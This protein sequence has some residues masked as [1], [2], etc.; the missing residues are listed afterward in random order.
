MKGPLRRTCYV[1]STFTIVNKGTAAFCELVSTQAYH[2]RG[3][4]SYWTSQRAKKSSTNAISGNSGSPCEGH[5]IMSCIAMR[6]NAVSGDS[7]SLCERY[8]ISDRTSQ[9]ALIEGIRQKE[10][11]KHRT[12]LLPKILN[13]HNSVA[14][15]LTVRE[16]WFQHHASH[17][18][19]IQVW[20]QS[21]A[22]LAHHARGTISYR[23]SQN[24][25]SSPWYYVQWQHWHTVREV[26][27]HIVHRIRSSQFRWAGIIAISSNAGTPC[28]WHNFRLCIAI[29]R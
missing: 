26:R 4:I 7:G 16:A 21:V 13:R 12:Y 5:N 15:K 23:T 22:T 17:M 3:S 10:R 6:R 11:R 18:R 2:A 29:R 27:F 1:F 9:Y 8:N 25:Y 24:A 14:Q 28:E 19:K 20:T